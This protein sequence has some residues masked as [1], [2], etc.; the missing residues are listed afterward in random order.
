MWYY[1]FG[2]FYSP[3]YLRSRWEMIHL[4]SITENAK[5]VDMITYCFCNTDYI[6]NQIA[7]I[8]ES[9]IKLQMLLGMMNT[10]SFGNI[11]YLA[12]NIRNVERRKFVRNIY[13]YILKLKS[14]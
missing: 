13:N 3:S 6:W 7:N 1:F 10:T 4:Q 11:A 2:L 14:V 8:S 9:S 12:I 5:Y